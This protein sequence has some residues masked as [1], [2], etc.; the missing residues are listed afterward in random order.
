M[1]E[2]TGSQAF[3]QMVADVGYFLYGTRTPEDEQLVNAQES[4]QL[5]HT[6]FL[7]GVYPD[8]VL[9]RR[10][11]GYAHRW[12]FLNPTTTLATVASQ[13]TNDLP[14]NF[15]G[16]R[17]DFAYS[18]TDNWK[19]LVRVEPDWINKQRSGSG[20]PEGPPTYYAIR[21]KAIAEATS[22]RYEV[23]WWFI[24][25][26]AYTLTYSYDVNQDLLT[27][28]YSFLLGSGQYGPILSQMARGEG[29]L[30]VRRVR[31]PQSERADRMLAAA[32]E[33]DLK[34]QGSKNLG[35]NSDGLVEDRRRHA[36]RND[37]T[38]S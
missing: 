8:N 1:A 3:D 11:A 18:S 15:G 13:T 27:A 4:V 23:V 26:A 12:S 37:V 7:A 28:D 9:D 30:L 33:Q 32:I 34:R 10:K 31:G 14:D 36:Y 22:E 21:P 35:Y 20:A 38:V 24:P 29:E 17:D 25:D 19:Q 5:A 6:I 16:M 2:P